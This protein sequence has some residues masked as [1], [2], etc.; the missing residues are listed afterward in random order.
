P[1]SGVVHTAGVLDDGVIGAL[2][3]ERLAGVF[4]PKVGAVAHLDELT[5]ELVP[6]LG[7]FVV[8][9]SA[10]GVFGSAGQGNYAAANAYL[11][12]VTQRRR[13][14]GLSGVS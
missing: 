4:A 3:P 13:A 7:A 11:D 8:F 10:A 9:S 5:R 6:E 1:L 2:T 12:A 14:A